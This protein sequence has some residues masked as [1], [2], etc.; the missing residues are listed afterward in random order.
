[1]EGR[2]EI[3]DQIICKAVADSI[4]NSIPDSIKDEYITKLLEAQKRIVEEWNKRDK[5]KGFKRCI[6]DCGRILKVSSDNF[7]R[8]KRNKDGLQGRCKRCMSEKRIRFVKSEEDEDAEDE[9][10][11]HVK[12][13]MA[14]TERDDNYTTE[15]R[16]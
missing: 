13:F 14:E 8:D 15:T 3:P 2:F 10:T 12:R 4:P 5:S 1:M 16:Q 11:R 9:E 6:G 7:R